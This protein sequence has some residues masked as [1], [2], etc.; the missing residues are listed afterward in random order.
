MR[1]VVRNTVL[2]SVTAIVCYVM[3]FQLLPDAVHPGW[4]SPPVIV[5]SVG[6]FVLLPLLY[7][8]WVIRYGN[9]S[10]AGEI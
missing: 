6:Y 5:A 2:Y 7:W 4:A 3:G 10:A 1:P 9:K 8:L